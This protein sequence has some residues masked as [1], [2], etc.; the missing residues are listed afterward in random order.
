L[1]L[2]RYCCRAI[3]IK[4]GTQTIKTVAVSNEFIMF[5]A[6]PE[7]AHCAYANEAKDA[8]RAALPMYFSG[9]FDIKLF[10]QGLRLALLTSR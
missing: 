1:F 5:R 9:C 6:C 4:A 2:S 7:R 8:T 3:P 10:P